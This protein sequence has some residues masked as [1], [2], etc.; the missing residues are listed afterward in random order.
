MLDFG[1]DAKSQKVEALEE[2]LLFFFATCDLCRTN[3]FP[4]FP[5]FY[6]STNFCLVKS[7]RK[8]LV[9]IPKPQ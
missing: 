3:N 8:T 4:S 5:I 6:I 1:I 7:K 2:F 9:L